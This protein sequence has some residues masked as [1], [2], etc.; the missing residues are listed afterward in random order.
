MNILSS[1][2]SSCWFQRLPMEILQIITDFL[3]IKDVISLSQ[4]CRNFY[5]FINDHNFWIHRIHC[6]FAPSI[7]QLYTFDLFQK[8]EIIETYNEIR[9]SGFT[10]VQTENELDRLAIN[11]AT[12]YNDEAI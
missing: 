4:T 1:N 12:H 10:H 5:R 8:P 11:S 2:D 7:A 9:P 6:Q 3:K